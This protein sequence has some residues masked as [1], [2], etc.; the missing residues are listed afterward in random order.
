MPQSFLPTPEAAGP[1][2]SAP[3]HFA[4]HDWLT[5]SVKALDQIVGQRSIFLQLSPSVLQSIANN[6]FTPLRIDLPTVKSPGLPAYTITTNNTLVLG[7]SWP[8]GMYR[9]DFAGIWAAPASPTYANSA[10][11][12]RVNVNGA[13]PNTLPNLVNLTASGQ[14]ARPAGAIGFGAALLKPLD[15]VQLEVRQDSGG[16]LDTQINASFLQLGF[17]YPA[18]VAVSP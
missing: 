12:A 1:I 2:A 13:V 16:N 6:T 9:I 4:H 5:A 3:G 10:R 7:D 18:T 15:T 17:M 8:V 14:S 11:S